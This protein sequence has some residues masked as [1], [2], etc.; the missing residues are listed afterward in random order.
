M[1]MWVIRVRLSCQRTSGNKVVR[2]LF[3]HGP[4][5]SRVEG[6]PPNGGCQSTNMS[7]DLSLSGT[8]NDIPH[9]R[10]HCRPHIGQ[11]DSSRVGYGTTFRTC[12]PIVAG[13]GLLV[14]SAQPCRRC[15]V[16][17]RTRGCWSSLARKSVGTEKRLARADFW[18]AF[19]ASTNTHLDLQR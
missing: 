19:M 9:V 17:S 6:K 7:R 18:R 10:T 5:R 4:A 12:A 1:E 14:R 2:G 13:L 8:R 11:P 16:P 15:S 3:Q